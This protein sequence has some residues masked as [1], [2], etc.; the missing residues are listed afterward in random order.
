MTFDISKQEREFDFERT[1]TLEIIDPATRA[2]NGLVIE[3]RAYRSE[4]V[5]RVERRLVNAGIVAQKKNPKRIGT[6]EEVED[7]G[8]EIVA[9]AVASWNMV[10]A[11][12][13]VLATPEA[14]IAIISQPKYF[15][16]GE[17]IDERA[18]D[19]TRFMTPSQTS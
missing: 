8:N 11:G 4:S 12:Q 10:N 13:P 15:Y 18:N 14:V 3:V 16:I 19:E 2:P 5:K 7:K 6:V 17:Q 1:S 9:A